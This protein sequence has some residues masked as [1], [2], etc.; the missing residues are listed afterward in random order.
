MRKRRPRRHRLNPLR[1]VP[2]ETWANIIKAVC[3]GLVVAAPVAA[4]KTTGDAKMQQT[5]EAVNSALA[6]IAQMAQENRQLALRTAAINRA[7]DEMIAQLSDEI[8]H[9]RRENRKLVVKSPQY[10]VGPEVPLEWTLQP[11]RK[12]K[13]WHVW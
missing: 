6:S 9:L 12:K 2:S 3:G 7:Q 5:N 13:W 4:V 10:Q 1:I 11:P 8:V